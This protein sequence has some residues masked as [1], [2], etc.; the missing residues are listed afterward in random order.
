MARKVTLDGIQRGVELGYRG[1][2]IKV[3]DPH[4]PE[5]S[6]RLRVGRRLFWR[7]AGKGQ[8]EK[9]RTWEDLIGFFMSTH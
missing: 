7:P 1:V 9:E 6:G 4:N 3:D 8:K 2:T 5:K